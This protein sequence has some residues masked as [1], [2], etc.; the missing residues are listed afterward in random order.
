MTGAEGD[1]TPNLTVTILGTKIV[2][3]MTF[4]DP[5]VPKSKIWEK[6][7]IRIGFRP[8]GKS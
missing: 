3:K 2:T 5:S 1:T 7:P 8:K 6:V 4:G